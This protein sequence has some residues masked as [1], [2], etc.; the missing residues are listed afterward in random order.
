MAIKGYSA[1]DDICIL[2]SIYYT[3]FVTSRVF[4]V[5]DAIIADGILD[6]YLSN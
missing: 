1:I 2:A 4:R 3:C 6:G 5:S